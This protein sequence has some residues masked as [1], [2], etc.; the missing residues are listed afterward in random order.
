MLITR[1]VLACG[2]A[3][4][5]CPDDGFCINGAGSSKAGSKRKGVY[6]I[7]STTDPERIAAEIGKRLAV[8]IDSDGASVN[9][10]PMA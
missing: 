6:C 7:V 2:G 3:F 8:R 10:C 5:V 9:A 1:P 4:D